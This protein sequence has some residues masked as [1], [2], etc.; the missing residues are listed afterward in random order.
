M[1][2]VGGDRGGMGEQG[3][4]LARERSAK[5]RIRDEA[6]DSEFHASSSAKVSGWWKSG[7]GAKCFSAR[8]ESLAFSSSL[9]AARAS[10]AM[11]DRLRRS[12]REG[13]QRQYVR[14]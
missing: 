14:E 1:R 3:H 5:R 6:I 7:S 12:R 10:A 11:R 8:Y 2:E 4:A 9:T 13:L